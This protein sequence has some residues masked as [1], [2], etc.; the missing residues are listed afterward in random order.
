MAGDSEI[1]QHAGYV[2]ILKMA[3]DHSSQFR[4]TT[5]HTRSFPG[6]IVNQLESSFSEDNISCGVV[7][8]LC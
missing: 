1:E 3:E 6:V 7:A 5:P 2:F 8:G 4:V